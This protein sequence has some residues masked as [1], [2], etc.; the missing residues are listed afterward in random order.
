MEGLRLL[1]ERLET[2]WSDLGGIWTLLGSVLDLCWRHFEVFGLWD[3][4]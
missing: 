2:S 3:D 1:W 4:F